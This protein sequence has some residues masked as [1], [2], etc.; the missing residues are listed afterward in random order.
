MECCSPRRRAGWFLIM[1]FSLSLGG[2]LGV[3][4]GDDGIDAVLRFLFGGN[5]E[6]EAQPAARV[7]Q[8]V[9]EDVP[10]DFENQFTPHLKKLLNA[11][12]H[13]AHKVC[14][15]DAEQFA[16]LQESGRLTIASI[17]KTYGEQQNQHQSH[18]WPDARE[19]LTNDFQKQIDASL[20]ADVATRYRDEIAARFGA[21]LQSARDMMVMLI[22]RKLSLTPEQNEQ[23]ANTL[24]EHWDPTWSRNMQVYLYDDYAPMPREDLL[25]SVLTER[26]QHVWA[27]RMNHG[28]ISFGWEQDLG[29]IGPLGDV[30]D[31][32]IDAPVPEAGDTQAEANNEEPE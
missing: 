22:D 27:S 23:V 4:R 19:V 32:V 11:E 7:E 10:A 30:G 20:P 25:K 1:A 6:A 17:A 31:L 9:V 29:L 13:F 28:R 8:A 21:K 16:R 12:L 14:G 2:G 18:E 3:A 15:L 5:R 26:Q 24:D